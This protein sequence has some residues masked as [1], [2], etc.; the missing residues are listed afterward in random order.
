MWSTA[1]KRRFIGLSSKFH[2]KSGQ[3]SADF[4]TVV[5]VHEPSSCTTDYTFCFHTVSYP[6]V[7]FITEIARI[8]TWLDALGQSRRW[9]GLPRSYES[10]RL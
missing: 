8:F 9:A 5:R 4:I 3:W 2:Y 7:V 10:L 1:E 6:Q